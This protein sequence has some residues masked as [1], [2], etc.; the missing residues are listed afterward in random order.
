MVSTDNRNCDDTLVVAPVRH[1]VTRNH[2]H[3]RASTD[4]A[5]TSLLPL[6]SQNGVGTFSHGPATPDEV[7]ASRCTRSMLTVG[8]EFPGR[9]P[10][11]FG[12]HPC[13]TPRSRGS[14]EE[15]PHMA[16]IGPLSTARSSATARPARLTSWWGD[17]GVK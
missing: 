12:S 7:R 6:R 14:F 3:R 2:G 4:G 16:E 8:H 13:P 15:Y 1:L 17:R 11:P 10:A 9:T 5:V